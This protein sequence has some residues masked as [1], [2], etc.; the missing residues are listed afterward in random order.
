M[1]QSRHRE[2]A[3]S[4][5]GPN[6]EYSKG[7]GTELAMPSFSTYLADHPSHTTAVRGATGDQEHL[8][9]NPSS[10]KPDEWKR[11]GPPPS[12]YFILQRKKTETKK[13]SPSMP[14]SHS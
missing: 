10:W 2:H 9:K 8:R 3:L 5:G 11:E 4:T 13:V 14:E 12:L 7:E 6:P 1:A